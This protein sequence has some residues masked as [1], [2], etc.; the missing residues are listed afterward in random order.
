MLKSVV[1]FWH[2]Y[3]YSCILD[4]FWFA[5]ALHPMLVFPTLLSDMYVDGTSKEDPKWGKS[6]KARKVNKRLF[7]EQRKSTIKRYANC[8]DPSSI[9]EVT[10]FWNLVYAAG[11]NSKFTQLR[12]WILNLAD[13]DR[14]H[15]LLF[16]CWT[17]SS[18]S[19][20]F[21]QVSYQG[22]LLFYIRNILI[23][24]NCLR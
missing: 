2:P 8:A 17:L 1:F 4:N 9:T 3:V 24:V 21:C 13:Q 16:I 20:N 19:G 14:D 5:L 10:G 11:N 23:F 7:Q 15:L 12:L 22:K 6:E 18:R